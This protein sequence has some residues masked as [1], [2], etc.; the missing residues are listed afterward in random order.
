MKL[1]FFFFLALIN[2]QLFPQNI[3][4]TYKESIAEYKKL[5][6]KSKFCKLLT[7]GKTDVGLP[8]NLFVI[9]KDLDFKPSSVKNKKKRI[10]LINNG[11]HPGEP[12]G[13]NACIQL[14]KEW[15]NNPKLIPDNV[16]ICIIPIYNIDGS[17]NRSCCSRA[18]QDGPQEYGF[19]GNSKNLD[20]N[21][22][23]IKCDSKNAKTFTEIF[24][25]WMPDVFVDTH[26]S[27]GA[28]YQYTMTLITSQYDKMNSTLA[29]FTKKEMVPYLF[30]S[31]KNSGNEMTPY[32]N[33][34]SEIPDSG[35]T[36]FLETPRFSTGYTTLFNTI[37]FVTETHMLKPFDKR[38]DATIT[39]LKHIVDFTKNN[40]QKIAEVRH[41][42]I[43]QTITQKTFSVNWELDTTKFEL[44]NFNG[45]EATYKPS[46]VSGLPRLY[47]NREKPYTKQ[48]KFY[49]NYKSTSTAEMPSF[50][51]IPQAWSEVIDRLKLNRVKMK[52]LQKDTALTVESYY[53][54]D[55]KSPKQPYESHY[56]HSGVKVISETQQLNYYKGDIVIE[57]NQGA[58]HYIAHTLDPKSVDSFFAWNFFDGIL[59]QK[60]WFSDYVFED[61]AANILKQN[62]E[63]KKQL[64]IKKQSDTKFAN[65]S[66]AQ[67][68]FIYKNSPYY[69]KSHNRYPIG[70]IKENVKLP[71]K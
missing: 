59:Q 48:I 66:F 47:Y 42:A 20:L 67:L 18:N 24:Q 2:L 26:T 33:T 40:S 43:E 16:V 27:D 60:E 35:I 57:T 62:P 54:T 52:T 15:I 63:L 10:I 8:L 68:Y 70:M 31:M 3:T 39:F 29:E 45:Y 7:Y 38:V 49:E 71:I 69:E 65:D 30:Q 58:N 36:A 37:S 64:D 4:P 21:R 32:V 14:S 1:H 6:A 22:D 11:I 51:I 13:I 53:I 25:E 12:E 46:E 17:L 55:Y 61:I 56:V 23:F 9:S 44:I 5:Q 50:Y 28:D 19:R 34:I 41:K